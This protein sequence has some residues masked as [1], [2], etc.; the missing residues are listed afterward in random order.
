VIRRLPLASSLTFALLML[1]PRAAAALP[2]PRAGER[3]DAPAL[4][5]LVPSAD[6]LEI[7]VAVGAD[8]DADG[9]VDVIAATDRDLI[10]WINDGR[11]H[12]RRRAA[13]R[14]PIADGPPAP[15]TWSGDGCGAEEAVQA[16][17]L[18]LPLIVVGAH[19]PP[20]DTASQLLAVHAVV[21]SDLCLSSRAPRAPPSV[22]V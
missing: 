7:R 18:L 20:S 17:T 14:H 1:M 6:R 11:G 3:L 5:R 10:V 8:I 12:F 16:G 2:Q 9:D 19:A 4:H 15:D 13:H 21:R 22:L